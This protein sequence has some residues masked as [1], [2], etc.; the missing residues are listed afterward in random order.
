VILTQ[1]AP[2]FVLRPSDQSPIAMRLEHLALTRREHFAGCH[3]SGFLILD[4]VLNERRATE[5]FPGAL[6]TR[7]SR[8]QMRVIAVLAGSPKCREE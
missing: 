4:E 6:F 8:V 7:G 5:R 2:E 3:S 1:V